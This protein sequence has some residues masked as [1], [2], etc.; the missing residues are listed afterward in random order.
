MDEPDLWVLRYVN[1]VRT[2]RNGL[3]RMGDCIRK[4][5]HI[6]KRQEKSWWEN[7]VMVHDV[8]H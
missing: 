7:E 2:R 6:F 4:L 3:V 8:L 5:L 1:C